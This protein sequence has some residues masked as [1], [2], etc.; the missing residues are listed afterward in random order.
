MGRSGH[1]SGAT[2]ALE[3]LPKNPDMPTDALHANLWNAPP[4]IDDALRT[5]F[6]DAVLVAGTATLPLA[7]IAAQ[8]SLP[9]NLPEDA[10]DADIAAGHLPEAIGKILIALHDQGGAK[11]AHL[12]RLA[13]CLAILNRNAESKATIALIDT[14]TERHPAI[15]ALKGYL[16]INGGE[17]EAGRSFLAKA[18]LASRGVPSHRSILH[19]TQHVLLVHQFGG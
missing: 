4:T 10:I 15:L 19:F 1:L 8:A 9:P 2:V 12:Y 13:L 5:R 17:V 3:L 6:A 16:A 18:A 14:D 7:D 11:A